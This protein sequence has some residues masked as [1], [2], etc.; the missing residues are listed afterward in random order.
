MADDI[1]S[2][3]EEY[4]EELRGKTLR[5]GRVYAAIAGIGLIC[6]VFQDVLLLRVGL[7]TL[8]RALGLAPTAFF[9]LA[10]LVLFRRFPRMIIPCH[11]VQVSAV[12]L[13]IC[14][15]TCTLFYQRPELDTFAYGTVGGIVICMV[16]AFVFAQGARRVLWAVLL[17]PLTATLLFLVLFCSPTKEELALFFNPIA[18]APA[19][20]AVAISQ[21]RAAFGEFSMR[22]LAIQRSE[23]TEKYAQA[24]AESNE[25]LETF[26]RAASHDLQQPLNTISG[27]LDLIERR[28]PTEHGGGSRVHEYMDF[29]CQATQRMS[30]LIK[31]L[32]TYSQLNTRR[33]PFEVVDMN[34]VL[35]EA[36]MNL[37][38]SISRSAAAL[39]HDEL[40]TVHGDRAQL[41]ALLQNLLDNA[42]KYR[43]PDVPPEIH[44]SS[45]DNGAA[46]RVSV[47]DNGVGFDPRF[48]EDAFKPFRRL[49]SRREYEGS[50]IGLASCTRIVKRHGGTIG[51]DTEPDQGA[52]FFFTLPKSRDAA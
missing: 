47:R 39:T 35:E 50:G 9:L 51:V 13:Q 42:I 4:L 41:T 14:G 46:Y 3:Q 22:R 11:I 37:Y 23:E 15:F 52:T 34:E 44:I 7:A 43:R 48:A 21:E 5:A 18:I 29:V 16:A 31:D 27:F 12:M 1:E 20:I 26:A 6:V 36:Q 25:E 28:L 19:L 33:D 32:L 17:L 30:D 45:K 10:S 2:V 8:W 40:P 24:L 49:H 38:S